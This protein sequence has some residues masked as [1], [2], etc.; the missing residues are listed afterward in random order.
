M[1]NKF[2]I[3]YVA[4]EISPFV[5]TSLL[6][7]TAN[8]LPKAL[9][10]LDHDIR[11]MM[12]NYRSV[13]ERRYVLRDVIRLKDMMVPWGNETHVANGKSAFLPDSKVQIY[14]FDQKPAFDR[15]GLY[16]DPKTKKAYADNAERFSLFCK[17]CLETLKL[18]HW[19]PDIIHCNDWPTALIPVLLKT[20]YRDEAFFKN[21]KVLLSVH[22]FEETGVSSSNLLKVITGGDSSFYPEGQIALDGQFNFLKAG[23][24]SADLIN[25]IGEGHAKNLLQGG[26]RLHGLEEVLQKRRKLLTGTP[27]GVDRKVWNPAANPHL[28]HHFSAGDL[29]GKLRGKKEFLES[30]ACL[31]SEETPWLALLDQGEGAESLEQIDAVLN[32]ALALNCGVIFLGVANPKTEK[33]LAKHRKKYAGKLAVLVGYDEPALH[34]GLAASDLVLPVSG[35]LLKSSLPLQAMAYG[36]VPLLAAHD[37]YTE[38]LQDCRKAASGN[39]FLLANPE[40][41]EMVKALKNAVTLFRDRKR[42]TK[43]AKAAMT[44]NP[45]W[46]TVAEEY[47]RLYAKL[48]SRGKK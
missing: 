14:F 37:G 43:V 45:S 8:A 19:Q 46:E 26:A 33:L 48:L 21:T 47:T 44:A 23:L 39:A 31:F 41:R 30:V 22:N 34:R 4:A 35:R 12:P 42:W 15:Q 24:L 3:F 2:K 16:R 1:K 32:E 20:T 5:G 36:V 28:L 27:H 29:A 17:G 10:E 40:A 38:A 7:D 18:L 9:K 11:V 25:V 13:N 6:A